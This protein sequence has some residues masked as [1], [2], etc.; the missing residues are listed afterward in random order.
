[1]PLT[2]GVV[3]RT[4]RT[5]DV[6]IKKGSNGWRMRWLPQRGHGENNKRHLHSRSHLDDPRPMN[7]STKI[8]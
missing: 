1:M 2:H 4:R 5:F 8:G 3:Y 7:K 6:Q